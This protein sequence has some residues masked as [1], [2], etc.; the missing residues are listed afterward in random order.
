MKQGGKIITHFNHFKVWLKRDLVT[1][2]HIARKNEKNGKVQGKV[3]P[4]LHK[5]T[6]K[7]RMSRCMLTKFLNVTNANKKLTKILYDII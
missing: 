3:G 6:F 2:E 1:E 4:F 7:Q 5:F